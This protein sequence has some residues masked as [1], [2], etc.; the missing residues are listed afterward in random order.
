MGLVSTKEQVI[1]NIRRFD[2]YS[3]SKDK[4]LLDFFKGLLNRGKKFVFFKIDDRF[5]FLPK[6]LCWVCRE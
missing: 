1:T 2:R 5:V 6:P 3:K 4:K